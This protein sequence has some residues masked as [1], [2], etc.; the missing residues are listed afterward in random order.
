MDNIGNYRSPVIME[1][2]LNSGSSNIMRTPLGNVRTSPPPL[3]P[4]VQYNDQQQNQYGSFMNGLGGQMGG[5]AYGGMYGPPYSGFG[6]GGYGVGNYGM[7]NCGFGGYGGGFNR[8]GSSWLN[9]HDPESRFIQLAEENSRPAFES[10]ESLVSAV[11]NIA[12]MLDSTFFAITSSFR[13]ILGVAANFGR[14]RGVFGQF[15]QTFAILRGLTWVY[16]KLLYWLR[17][18]NIDPSSVMFK[19]AFAAAES[20]TFSINSMDGTTTQPKGQSPWPVIVFL[21]F[22]FTAP[23]LVMKLLGN[24]T[25]T[26]LAETKDPRRWTNPIKSTV[27]YDFQARNP[28][29]LNIKNGETIFIAPKEIQNTQKLLNTGWALATLDGINSGLIPITY[30]QR[31]DRINQPTTITLPSVQTTTENKL[32]QNESQNLFTENENV[33]ESIAMR[34]ARNIEN[35][36]E[37]NLK[38]DETSSDN[39]NGQGNVN[40]VNENI[41]NFMKRNE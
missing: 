40:N 3:P 39:I 2:Q 32:Q 33:N 30:V 9:P 34:S 16:K 31:L 20:A 25:S 4:S 38:C 24:L 36:I 35:N 14:L 41:A 11:A 26:A 5:G 22:I 7:G 10:I 23:Y 8:F 29:E 13:A 21:S 27:L 37:K 12:S 19:E 15:W 18:S 28:T 17:L 1:P 6:G